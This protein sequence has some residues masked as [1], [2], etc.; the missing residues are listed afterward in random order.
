MKFDPEFKFTKDVSVSHII[1]DVTPMF[2]PEEYSLFGFNL[3]DETYIFTDPICDTVLI[4][5]L[6]E[7][8]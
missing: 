6:N 8:R 7:K 1:M 5:F 2:D 3:F 4:D